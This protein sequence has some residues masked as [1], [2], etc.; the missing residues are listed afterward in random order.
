MTAPFSILAEIETLWPASYDLPAN[1]C[2]DVLRGGYDIPF[3]PVTPPVILDLGANCGAFVRWA[4]MRWPGCAIHA[5]EPHPGNCNLLEYTA[6][7]IRFSAKEADLPLPSIT[8]HQQAVGG[9]ACIAP[10]HE[11]GFNCGEWS[12]MIDTG[13]SSIPVEVIAA[14][15]LPKADILKIDTE[16][17]EAV[18]LAVLASA[19]RLSEFSAIMLETHSA[20]YPEP[21][22]FRL[23]ESGFTLTGERQISEHRAE[24]KFVRSDLLQ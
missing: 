10:L 2:E 24:L 13:R 1:H 23:K 12:L 15:D 18:I 11:G 19:G 3:D 22:K 5:Y 9:H 21:I 20:D 6:E 14:T 8:T 7:L 17:M 16:G 4:A